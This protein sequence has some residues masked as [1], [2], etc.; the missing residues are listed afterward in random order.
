MNCKK[1]YYLM[2]DGRCRKSIIINLK[3]Y[4]EVYKINEFVGD[5][6]EKSE[7]KDYLLIELVINEKVLKV[8]KMVKGIKG[9][10]KFNGEY[11]EVY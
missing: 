2:I 5:I 3:K 7:I 11:I 1:K 9:F 8:I 6:E 4:I 10:V